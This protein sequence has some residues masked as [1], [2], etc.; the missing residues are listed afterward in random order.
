VVRMIVASLRSVA[1]CVI[2]FHMTAAGGGGVGIMGKGE[3][4]KK[5]GKEGVV[6]GCA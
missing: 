1:I 6:G 5:G 3:I 4:G 2:T